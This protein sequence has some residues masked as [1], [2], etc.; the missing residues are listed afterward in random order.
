MQWIQSSME[1]SNMIMEK[2]IEE[3]GRPGKYERF[4]FSLPFLTKIS[5]AYNS[6]VQKIAKIYDASIS[7]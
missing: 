4:F 1:E 7:G 3:Q 2:V 6:S 5:D